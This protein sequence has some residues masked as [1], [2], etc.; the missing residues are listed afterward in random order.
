MRRKTN[1]K[2]LEGF[3]IVGIR[4]DI[5]EAAAR[6]ILQKGRSIPGPKRFAICLKEAFLEKQKEEEEKRRKAE[7]AYRKEQRE[8]RPINKEMKKWHKEK[9]KR[10]AIAKQEAKRIF[11]AKP[12]D[13]HKK[14]RS[15]LKWK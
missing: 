15:K 12:Y 1:Q 4:G 13:P 11:A 9:R 2:R 7:E 10:G 3:G 5:N 14:E 6:R 8:A